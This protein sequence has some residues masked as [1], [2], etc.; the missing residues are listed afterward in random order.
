MGDKMTLPAAS[1]ALWFTVIVIG[2]ITFGY[3]LSMLIFAA[4]FDLPVWLQRPLRFV[5]IAA[6]T[7]IIVPE[8]LL[9]NGQLDLTV[10]NTRLLAGLVAAVVAWHTRNV[11]LT[12]AIGMAVLWGV[13]WLG[14]LL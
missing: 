9:R 4:Q 6:L 3:R 12:I 2:L 5:P 1:F 10:G 13:Q 8:L 7:A 14:M 11:L